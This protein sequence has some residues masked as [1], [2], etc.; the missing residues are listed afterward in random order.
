MS[1]NKKAEYVNAA[2]ESKQQ[3]AYRQIK[4]DIL[5][6]TYPE[7]TVLIERKLCE[8]YNVSRSPIRN[9]L[10]QLSH[11]GLLTFIPGKGVTVAGFSIEDILEVYDLI[12]LL[13]LYA[14]HVLSSDI[15]TDFEASLK[16]CLE[17]MKQCIE[18][19]DILHANLWDQNFHQCF[20]SSVHNKRLSSIYEQLSVQSRRFIA[21]VL[22]DYTLAQRSYS[23][24]LEIYENVYSQHWES[25][26]KSMRTHYKNIK[27]YYIDKL[28][29]RINI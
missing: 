16:H 8:I 14:V 28:I 17:N 4:A 15:S 21:T 6:N 18:N 12:E 23:E 20:I 25:A 26:E 5:N 9:A 22:D 19:H 27:Q 24:H 2:G 13:Q 29:H 3:Q 1:E 7:G 11:E 10:Q